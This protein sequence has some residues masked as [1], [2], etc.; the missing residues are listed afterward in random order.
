MSKLPLLSLVL[1][2][3]CSDSS[4][5]APQPTPG[6]ALPPA[7]QPAA[8][9][10]VGEVPTFPSTRPAD[11]H[12]WVILGMDGMD[13][14]VVA[15]MWARGGMKNLQ[16][17]CGEGVC[18]K[19]SAAWASSPVIWTTVATGLVPE[20][21][22]IDRFV[23]ETMSGRVPVGSKDR[24]T[25]TLW[26]FASQAGYSTAVLGWLVT[27]PAYPLNGLNLSDRSAKLDSGTERLFPASF[28]P[29]F[30]AALPAAM[31][32][33]DDTFDH[34]EWMAEN[35][36]WVSFWTPKIVASGPDIVFS[37]LRC[38]DVVSHKYWGYW[39]TSAFP[40]L[41]P[42][43][44]AQNMDILPN[45]Y[46]ADDQVLGRVL[47]VLPPDTNLIVMSDHG[48]H[49]TPNFQ[50][51]V[52]VYTDKLLEKLGY[53]I[54]N[55]AGEAIPGQSKMVK[56]HTAPT[57]YRQKVHFQI[58]GRDVGGT[59]PPAQIE[60]LKAELKARLRAIN[61]STGQQAFQLVEP[62]AQEKQVGAD[63]VIQVLKGKVSQQIVID[64]ATV[65]GV[66]GPITM[67]T[68]NHHPVAPNGYFLAW[69]PDIDRSFSAETMRVQDVAPTIAYGL[70]LPVAQD[71]D[72]VAVKELFTQAF[73]DSH[74]L[75]TVPTWGTHD[76]APAVAAG[77]DESV[78]RELQTLGYIQ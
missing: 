44:I 11:V 5:V 19:S 26:D 14:R 54:T 45:N 78:I 72:G 32:G 47:E 4:D 60:T 63:V 42:A 40:K 31:A 33:R 41:D 48:F 25:A 53:A 55:E 27:F 61:Y 68:G 29:T 36:A 1:A 50:I 6:E 20:R 69:G 23:N 10:P 12:R 7:E 52:R 28:Q 13:P 70:G 24:K 34:C 37:Y 76:T 17:L 22:G 30:D 59:I 15:D 9:T 3:A 57:W 38:I 16:K 67:N 65:D 66:I 77:G 39:E 18:L 49:A 21:H 64:G 43:D 75:K 71:A 74:E 73:R 2:A 58:D 46:E 35:D 51:D 56:W 8:A 62:D